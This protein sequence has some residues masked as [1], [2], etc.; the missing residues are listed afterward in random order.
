VGLSLGGAISLEFVL[1]YPGLA[2]TLTLVDSVLWGAEWSPAEGAI[3]QAIWQ[4]GREESVQAGRELWLK[5]ILF[6][7]A[8]EQPAV[9]ARLHEMTATYSGWHWT[10]NDRGYYPEKPAAYR[11]S[12]ISVPTYVIVGERDTP[13]LLV[14]A[15]KLASEIPGAQKALMRGVGHMANMEGPDEFN[16]L[17]LDFLARRKLTPPSVP[18]AST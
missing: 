13:D 11:L 16:S 12:E 5:H 14:V 10:H 9:A 3:Y 17:L 1:R 8:L 15:D 2:R 6:T 4:A 7:P 18:P